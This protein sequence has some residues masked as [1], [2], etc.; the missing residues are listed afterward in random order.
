M[1]FSW[2][3]AKRLASIQK[4]GVDFIIA[5]GMAW[6]AV[7]T[8]ADLR[9]G[10]EMRLQAILSLDARLYFATFTLR[11]NTCHRINVRKASNRE[12]RYYESQI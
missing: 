2:D 10:P 8:R 4:H 5:Y 3:P 7:V 1:E 6:S 9:H 12:I 11:T